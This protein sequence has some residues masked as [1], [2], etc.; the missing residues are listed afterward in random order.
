VMNAPNKSHPC[1]WRPKGN[2]LA[3]G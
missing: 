2:G 3:T 1:Y